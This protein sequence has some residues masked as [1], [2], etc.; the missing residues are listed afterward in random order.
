[1]LV[2]WP[3]GMYV[4]PAS[5]GQPRRGGGAVQLMYIHKPVVHYPD[6]LSGSD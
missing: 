6:V 3:A 4:R 1:V 2:V 5:A